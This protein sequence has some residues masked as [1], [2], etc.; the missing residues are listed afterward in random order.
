MKYLTVP[1]Q[2]SKQLD[3]YLYREFPVGWTLHS[4]VAVPTT[5]FGIGGSAPS[6]FIVILQQTREQTKA[7]AS[8]AKRK[9]HAREA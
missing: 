3:D 2:N 7:L 8:Q 5:M 4:V 9:K 1:I 6:S